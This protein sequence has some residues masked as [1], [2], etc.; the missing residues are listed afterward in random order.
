MPEMLLM[1]DFAQEGDAVHHYLADVSGVS[2][3]QEEHREQHPAN[4]GPA[5]PD[6]PTSVYFDAE[7]D[8]FSTDDVLSI[9]VS[10]VPSD[11][12]TF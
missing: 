9:K 3:A 4:H 6:S 11:A 10:H 2:N 5:Y 7:E 12:V 8:A 1:T